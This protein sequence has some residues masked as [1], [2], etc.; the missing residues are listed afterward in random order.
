M[1]RI[2]GGIARMGARAVSGAAAAA[3]FKLIWHRVDAGR[4]APEPVDEERGWRAVLAAAAL[5][6]A[7]FAVTK[8]AMERGGAM[9]AHRARRLVASR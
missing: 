7:L 4:D 3:A 6:G 1:S 8:A 9:G 2:V 5:H